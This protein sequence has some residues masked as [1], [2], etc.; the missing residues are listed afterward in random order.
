M[1]T[2]YSINRLQ[3]HN[4]IAHVQHSNQQRMNRKT[5]VKR[6][7]L[8]SRI[9]EFSKKTKYESL[10]MAVVPAIDGS[11][12]MLGKGKQP[13]KLLSQVWIDPLSLPMYPNKMLY[14]SVGRA[15]DFDIY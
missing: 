5:L 10:V 9:D 6:K 1:G 4:G 8:H 15:S 13:N 12:T 7:S 3:K 14:S 11:Q 2:T